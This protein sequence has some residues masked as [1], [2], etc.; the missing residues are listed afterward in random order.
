MTTMTMTRSG[1][2]SALACA[3]I[4]TACGGQ[5]A[6]QAQENAATTSAAPAQA[7]PPAS[8]PAAAPAAPARA[9]ASIPAAYRGEWANIPANCGGET[10]SFQFTIT[11]GTIQDGFHTYTVATVEDGG[12]RIT[13]GGT[14]P[15][16]M[17]GARDNE[18]TFNLAAGRRRKHDDLHDADRPEHGLYPLPGRGGLRRCAALRAARPGPPRSI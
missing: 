12:G 8:A 9:G 14:S 6:P 18:D 7:G 2:L 10:H 16:A 15:S 3:T 1:A 17:A 5:Q 4:L 13:V 11:E